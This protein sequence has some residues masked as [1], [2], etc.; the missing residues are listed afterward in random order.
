[1]F[2]IRLA[3][4]DDAKGILDIYSPYIENTSYTFEG[5]TP[6]I[7]EFADRIEQYLQNW[8][9]LVVESDGIIAGYA[10]AS[11]YRERIGYQWCCEASIYMHDDFQKKGIG[12]VLYTSLFEILSRQGYR[13]VYAVI[14][15]PNEKS[16]VFHESLG[17]KWFTTYEN[18]GY[19][20]GR[21][22]NVGWWRLILNEFS[23]EPD[24]PVHFS[25]MDKSFLSGF[26]ERNEKDF[27]NL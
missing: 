1:M 27:F 3:T 17:F 23:D 6:T 4:P 21:W 26:F 22:K 2:R 13:N 9:W 12:K 11:R 20:L 14:N 18:V 16:V 10:Y 5:V 24:A 25:E 19:K 8:P 15:L 7:E